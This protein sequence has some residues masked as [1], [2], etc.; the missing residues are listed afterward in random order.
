MDVSI[1]IS[2]TLTVDEDDA[3]RLKKEG[4]TELLRALQLQGAKVSVKVSEAGKK[5]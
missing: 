4:P 2:G 1:A 5:G 3:K